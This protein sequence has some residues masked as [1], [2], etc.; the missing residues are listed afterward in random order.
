MGFLSISLFT[1]TNDN[2]DTKEIIIKEDREFLQVYTAM[3]RLDKDFSL[4]Y[5]PLYFQSTEISKQKNGSNSNNITPDYA[6]QEDN[7]KN[8]Y[9][10]SEKFPLATVNSLPVPAVTQEDKNSLRFMTSANKR[11]FEDQKQSRHAWVEYYLAADDRE[12]NATADFQL[13]RREVKTNIYDPHLDFEKVP[14][15]VL[16]R[17]VKE[18][19]MEFYSRDQEKWVDSL[20]LISTNEKYTPRS[21]RVTITWVDT[22]KEERTQIRIFRPYWPYFDVVAD[23]TQKQSQTTTNSNGKIGAPQ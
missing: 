6:Q 11:F 20:S 7:A 14:G 22:N 9:Q 2:I 21:M 16:L 23:E 4:I 10:I 8:K 12:D 1:I 5:S 15:H 17:G 13:M 3:Y 19:K 18:F